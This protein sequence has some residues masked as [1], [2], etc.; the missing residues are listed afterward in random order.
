MI[1]LD[2]LQ[3]ALEEVD[4]AYRHAANR[5]KE[6]YPAGA[7]VIVRTQRYG[8]AAKETEGE[9]RGASVHVSQYGASV[10][11]VVRNLKTGKT[12]TRYPSIDV[13]GL[14]QVRLVD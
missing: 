7:R 9:V 14:P 13:A 6:A 4:N 2:R 5:A 11:V 1:E 8:Y 12:S 10:H 3:D